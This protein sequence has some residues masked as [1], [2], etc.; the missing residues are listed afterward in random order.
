ML[1]DELKEI[2]SSNPSGKRAYDTIELS[3][4]QFTQTHYLVKDNINHTWQLEDTSSVEFVAFGFDIKLPE[5]GA[6]QQ[7]MTFVFDNVGREIMSELELAASVI[8]EPIVL[9]YRSYA[10][11]FVTPQITAIE[12]SLTNIVADNKSITA[13][14]TRPDLYKRMIP[15]GN[16]A[17][18]D[19]RFHGLY[20]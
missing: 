3:H 17:F 9:K 14:A 10:D 2:Y 18:F 5:K 8:T 12:L 16:K 19:N 7:D 15:S 4:S 1:S 6:I 11:G 13:V 20:V